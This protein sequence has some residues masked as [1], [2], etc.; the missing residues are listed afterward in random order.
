MVPHQSLTHAFEEIHFTQTRLLGLCVSLIG[1]VCLHAHVCA[2][3]WK[4]GCAGMT[5][6]EIDILCVRH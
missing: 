1:F 2:S 4:C 6:S 3:V 5:T